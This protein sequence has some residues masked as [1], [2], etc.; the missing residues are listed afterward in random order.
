M[1]KRSFSPEFRLSKS[2]QPGYFV[3]S[4]PNVLLPCLTSYPHHASYPHIILLHTF[5]LLCL[6][7]FPCIASPPSPTD[8]I[9][10]ELLA[11]VPGDYPLPPDHTLRA[12]L[13]LCFDPGLFLTSSDLSCALG[14]S[15]E[16]IPYP[17]IAPS[18]PHWVY[19]H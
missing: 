11:T 12:S 15:L 10:Y 2:L 5:A 13:G 8:S 19:T 9:S 14:I 17:Q 16:T 7:L 4:S 6:A 3:S 18:E 1:N